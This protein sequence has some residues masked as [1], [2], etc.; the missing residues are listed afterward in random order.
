MLRFKAGARRPMVLLFAL[1]AVLSLTGGGLS[2]A[3]S[4]QKTAGELIVDFQNE[5]SQEQLDTR[6]GSVAPTSAQRST[7]AQLG[8]VV[9]W[10]RFGT[11]SSLIKYGGFLASGI[12]AKSA[13][14][15][16]RAW[17]DANA[18]LFRLSSSDSL[19]LVS[20]S[21]LTETNSYAVNLHQLVNG[22]PVSPEGSLSIGVKDSANSGWKVAYVSSTL[23]TD[24]G[25]LE[26]SPTLTST[27][28]FVSAARDVDVPIDASDVD[29]DGRQSGWTVLELDDSSEPQLVRT[30]AFPTINRGVVRAF[31][32]N[33]FD[34]VDKGYQH[35]IDAQTGEV[36]FRANIVHQALDEDNPEWKVFPSNPR[37]SALNRFPWNYQSNDIREVWCWEA[38]RGCNRVI[39]NPASP[40]GWDTDAATLAPTNTTAGNNN[41]AAEAWVIEAGV[42]VPPSGHRPESPTRDY[43]YDWTNEW[44]EEGCNPDT[45]VVGSGNDI[46]AAAVNLFAMHN[47]MHDWSY[48][49]GFT[50]QNWNAQNFNFGQG[51]VG[52]DALEGRV[53]SG[54]VEPG[55]RD[56]ANMGT[57]PDGTPSVT[58]MFM[59]QPIAGGFYA[60]C[61][62]GD[63]DQAVIAHEFGHMVENRMIGKG[64]RRSGFHAGAMGE[65][66]SDLMAMEYLNEYGFVTGGVQRYAV[67]AYVT[68][69]PVEAIRNYNMS[70]QSAGRFPQEARDHD[71]NPLNFSSF[72]YDIVGPQVHATGEIWSATNFDLRTLLNER[73]GLGNFNLQRRCA[74][75]ELP[76]TSC[77]GNRRWVQLMFDSFLLQPTAPSMLDARDAILAADI[78]RFGGA[79]QDLLWLG[80]A[81]R[82]FGSGASVE[83]ENDVTP[84][85]SWESP[86]HDEATLTFEAFAKDEGGAPIT[87]FDVYVGDY[88]ARSVPIDTTEP[89]VPGPQRGYNFVAVAPGYGHVRFAVR[90]LRPGENRTIAIHFPTN[91]ASQ[92]QG[93]TASGDGED[94]ASLIDDSEGTNWG[95]PTLPNVVI[96]DP[97]SSAAGEYSASGADFGPPPTEEGFDGDIVL[98]NDGSAN[99]THGCDPLVGFPSGAIALIDRGTCSFVQKVNN[100]QDAGAGAVIVANDRP[101]API[102]LTGDDPDIVI[103]SVMVSQADGNA[104][105][106]GLPAT[107]TVARRQAVPAQGQQAVI[108]LDGEQS[109]NVAKVSAMLVPGQNRFTALRQFEL[110]VCTAGGAD[111]PACDGS[112]EAGWTSITVSHPDAFPAVNPRPVAPELQ[113]RAFDLSDMATATHVKFIVLNNQCTGQP[114]FQGEQDQDPDN[115]TDCRDTVVDEQV[116]AAELQLFSSEAAV[117]GAYLVE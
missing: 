97:P 21:R 26:G 67:G 20:S 110:Q 115:S 46:D 7:V 15:A 76:A 3:G 17:V 90:N 109:F 4:T 113:L 52:G 13:E 47:R 117:D 112:V 71:T 79:N 104:I 73:Y 62:D 80:F 33:Y 51:G 100:A 23:V 10:N 98:V 61:V 116:R 41:N 11:P 54:A 94:H 32:T 64:D 25:G 63:Y 69:N 19:E 108:E 8:A 106:T 6:S 82:G 38:Q 77:P 57:R 42:P 5:H 16:A 24:A 39:A 66:V 14:S 85:P 75:G 95:T 107:G 70:W 22:V 30:V 89:L 99:P 87:D 92:S 43:I 53:Q 29:R 59:W 50:E 86:L 40:A 2:A 49:L 48:N 60:P 102:T 74:D 12:R 36:L 84:V 27:R 88:E 37:G 101:G 58:N 111:N 55:S 34:G 56:N 81:R 83:D 1:A 91:L 103:S 35:I 72:G 9:R 18:S 78:M 114:S 45:F 96:V 28:A 105:R 65:S 68:G 93:A 31:E 44:F